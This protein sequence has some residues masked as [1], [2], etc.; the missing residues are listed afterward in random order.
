MIQSSRFRTVEQRP[1]ILEARDAFKA[2]HDVTALKAT[3]YTENEVKNATLGGLNRIA[4]ENSKRHM[5]ITTY[6]H[7]I[8]SG[9]LRRDTFL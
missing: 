5:G 9:L 3:F 1:A 8:L 6:G 7:L 2:Q 4:I